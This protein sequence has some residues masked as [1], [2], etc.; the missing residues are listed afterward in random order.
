MESPTS[1]ILE[2]EWVSLGRTH[3]TM[4]LQPGLAKFVM[5]CT[6]NFQTV[7]WSNAAS[8]HLSNIVDGVFKEFD[9][10]LIFVWGQENVHKMH[11]HSP[12]RQWWLE[13]CHAK[14]NHHSP[15][16]TLPILVLTKLSSMLTLDTTSHLAALREIAPTFIGE[17]DDNFL[18]EK[19]Q[20]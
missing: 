7:V 12:R 15:W 19:L 13:V 11:L 18:C 5:F 6:K 17:K 4:M 20:G 9:E 8:W 3:G 2:D 1:T 10:K 14:T 16:P